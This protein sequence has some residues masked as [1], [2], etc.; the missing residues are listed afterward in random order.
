MTCL[1]GV[2]VA[3]IMSGTILLLIDLLVM[4]DEGTRWCSYIKGDGSEYL[5]YWR[6]VGWGEVNAHGCTSK[7]MRCCKKER[8]KSDLHRANYLADEM[9]FCLVFGRNVGGDGEWIQCAY[10]HRQC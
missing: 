7:E 2:A 1:F 3:Q 10:Q 6:E 4:M 9:F 5:M 8:E